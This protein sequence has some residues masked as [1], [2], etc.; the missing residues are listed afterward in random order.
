M[1]KS[2]R[3]TNH[4]E[5][6]EQVQQSV[7]RGNRGKCELVLCT[8]RWQGD[9]LYLNLHFPSTASAA[10]ITSSSGLLMQCSVISPRPTTS[11]QDQ[12]QQAHVPAS[13]SLVAT[14]R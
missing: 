13:D 1:A 14:P 8:A 7:I 9:S 3:P 12:L 4:G 10:V 5:P 2:F 11:S 6:A